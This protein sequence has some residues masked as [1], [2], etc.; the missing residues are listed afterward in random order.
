MKNVFYRYAKK[1]LGDEKNTR[2][3]EDV[4]IDDKALKDEY[5][6]LYDLCFDHDI[7]TAEAIL[8]GWMGFKFRR[9]LLGGTLEPWN[10]L[11]DRR[12]ET[13]MGSGKDRVKWVLTGDKQFPVKSLYTEKMITENCNFP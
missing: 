13:G 11:K 8:K 12:E 3:W 7:T 9:T 1:K 10:N 2:F 6:R 4:W 5:P